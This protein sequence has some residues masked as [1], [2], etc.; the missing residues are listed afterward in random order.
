MIQFLHPWILIALLLI[1]FL[2]FFFKKRSSFFEGTMR[3]SSSTLFEGSF[4]R[5][6]ELRYKIILYLKILTLVLIIL[7]IARPRK[8]DQLQMMNVDVVDIILVIDISSSMLAED[9]KPNRLE[10]VK[11]AALNFIANRQEDRIGLLV[12][13]GETFIQCPLTT[14]KQVLSSLLKDIRIAEKEYDGTAIG[15]AIANATNRLRD[16]K[17]KSKVMILLS[18]GSNNAGELDPITAADLA[19]QF[20]IK[21]YTIGAATDQSITYIPGVGRMVNEIDEK[22]LKEISK[23]TG[24]R[25]FRAKDQDMLTEIYAQIDSMER[26]EIEV[27]SYTKYKELFGWFLIPALIIG[28]GTETLS[29]TVFKKL[30]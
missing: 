5:K 3:I 27:K 28:M 14:D 8:I 25:Y 17:A 9:F 26:T 6:G 7:S 21:I 23:E 30:T 15:M 19:N 4:H 12:F 16:S 20:D 2:F 24:G 29:R 13:A 1:P 18:D 22:T 11:E 10:A